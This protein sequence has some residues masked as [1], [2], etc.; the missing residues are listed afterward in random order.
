MCYQ[1]CFLVVLL[2]DVIIN[3]KKMC[4]SFLFF[5]SKIKYFSFGMCFCNFF[6][7]LGTMS[8]L[9]NLDKKSVCRGL[10]YLLRTFG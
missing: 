10:S 7:L 9:L 6:R 3:R 2:T 1:C 8:S 4:A 5:K